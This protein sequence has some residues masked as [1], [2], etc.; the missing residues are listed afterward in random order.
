MRKTN[1]SRNNKGATIT[2][3]SGIKKITGGYEHS[4]RKI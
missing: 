3:T 4:T 1:A 2:A